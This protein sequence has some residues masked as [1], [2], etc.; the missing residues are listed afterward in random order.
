[1]KPTGGIAVRGGILLL[2]LGL[3]AF[4]LAGCSYQP[5]ALEVYPKLDHVRAG[6][7]GFRQ[8]EYEAVKRSVREKNNFAFQHRE[9]AVFSVKAQEAGAYGWVY[10]QA[11]VAENGQ[12]QELEITTH[13]HPLVDQAALQAA[14]ECLFRRRYPAAEPGPYQARF[15]YPFGTLPE[16]PRS[17]RTR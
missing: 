4:P 17:N 16:P 8:S 5:R 14:R 2:L 13:V 12:V 7:H 3:L 11:T 10:L 15:Y 9:P 6:S 1:M